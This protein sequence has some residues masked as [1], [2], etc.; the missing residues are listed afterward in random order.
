M[1]L[2]LFQTTTV[3]IEAGLAQVGGSA[4]VQSD[5]G[6]IIASYAGVAIL[7]GAIATFGYLILGAI[8]WIT[9]GGDT[10][11][12]DK[13]RNQIVQSIIGLAVLASS[14]AIFSVVQYFFG[15]N[16]LNSGASTTGGAARGGGNS[17]VRTLPTTP[18]KG[19]P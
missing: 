15:I 9:A 10:G 12:I 19:T 1:L 16:I 17:A 18:W 14:F 7:I 11:K 5:L 6:T 2:S 13:A 3:D 4:V 8:H